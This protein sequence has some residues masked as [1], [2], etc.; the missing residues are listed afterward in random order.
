M[1]KVQEKKDLMAA[2][3]EGKAISSKE[4]FE[5]I[6][7]LSVPAIMAQLTS[8]VMSYLD[9]SMVGSLGA[10]KTAAIGLMT[11]T[12][13]LL[14]SVC[15]AMATGFTIQAAQHLG[16][17]EK[18]AARGVFRQ[19]L[20]AII[21][22]CLL[23]TA[24]GVGISAPLPAWLGGDPAIRGDA[25][26]YLLI[27]ACSLP[28]LGLNMLAGGMLQASGNMKVPGLLNGL[29]CVLDMILNALLIFPGEDVALG[30]G[31]LHI[32]GAGMGVAGAALGTALSVVIIAVAML[33][34]ASVRSP[35]F[36]IKRGDSFRLSWPCQ[37][38]AFT[39]SLPVALQNGMICGAFIVVTRV[40]AG[41]GTVAVAAHSLAMTVEG[42][43]YIPAFGMGA[44]AATLVGQSF[45]AGRRDLVRQFARKSVFA[46]VIVV[47]VLS[48]VVYFAAPF[49]IAVMTPDPAVRELGTQ[50]LRIIIL[51]EPLYA[52]SLV[53][54]GAF[55]GAGDTLVPSLMSLFSLWAVRLPLTIFAAGQF[56]LT[57]VWG[58]M[59]F[60]ICFRG[61]IFL[62]RL[63][64]GRWMN[65]RGSL[66]ESSKTV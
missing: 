46:G 50:V 66:P 36:H 59:C 3:R 34:Y 20:V 26:V 29:M 54:S 27:Y 5:I 51:A 14:G 12:T 47:A 43:S 38:R 58:A 63:F 31:T 28:F 49:M 53:S 2:I 45:G 18:D 42:L 61:V 44:A 57:G 15:S 64:R 1:D 25:S 41:L 48:W 65:R 30:M 23:F 4:E 32:P 60:E 11:T 35:D 40:I 19:G 37:K 7:R 56:G 9:A 55:Q 13:W 10:E 16:A 62:I 22:I 8:V 17:N 33:W 21:G 6:G 24:I 39:L 52:V